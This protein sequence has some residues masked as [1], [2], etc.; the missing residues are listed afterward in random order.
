MGSNRVGNVLFALGHTAWLIAAYLRDHLHAPERHRSAIDKG[1][2]PLEGIC[3]D[4]VDP[5][6]G[7]VGV[8]PL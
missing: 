7:M 5:K 8:E 4:T 3:Q 1:R 6:G 2:S